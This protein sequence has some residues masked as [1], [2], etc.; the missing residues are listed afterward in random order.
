MKINWK[1]VLIGIRT[2]N[3]MH[4]SEGRQAVFWI[5]INYMVKWVNSNTS[6][7]A[8][9]PKVVSGMGKIDDFQKLEKDT[10]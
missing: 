2:C 1:G 8:G 10:D 3:V 4:C 5:Y 9:D 6:L 7:F